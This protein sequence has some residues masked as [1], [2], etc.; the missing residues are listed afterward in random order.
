MGTLDT[1]GTWS[2]TAAKATADASGNNIANTYLTKTAGVTD[3]SWTGDTDKK[4]SKTINGVA[5]DI[6]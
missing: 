3:V 6:I 2:G 5:S 4:I 1:S